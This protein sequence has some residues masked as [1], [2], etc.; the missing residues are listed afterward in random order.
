MQQKNIFACA[1]QETWSLG[2]EISE[3][4]GC[5]IIEH[6]SKS[7]PKRDHPPGGVAIILSPD[8]VRAWIKAGSCVLQIGNRTFAIKLEMEDIKGN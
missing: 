7:K 8:A 2:N 4:Y 3:I 6:G 1:I 5:Y